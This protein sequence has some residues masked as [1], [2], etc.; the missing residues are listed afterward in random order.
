MEGIGGR[1][2]NHLEK[3]PDVSAVGQQVGGTAGVRSDPHLCV[4]LVGVYFVGFV[5]GSLQARHHTLVARLSPR[6]FLIR[7]KR[8][9]TEVIHVSPGRCGIYYVL[10]RAKALGARLM[11][12]GSA[13][14]A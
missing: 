4:R 14:T 11:L 12:F 9:G 13:A 3:R 6:I 2:N 7:Y 8:D 10:R 5:A 1:R